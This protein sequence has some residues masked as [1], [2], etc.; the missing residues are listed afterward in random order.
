LLS[1]S[2]GSIASI[3]ITHTIEDVFSFPGELANS[4]LRAAFLL[5]LWTVIARP[6]YNRLIKTDEDT[7]IKSKTLIIIYACSFLLM[8]ISLFA[9]SQAES[10]GYLYMGLADTLYSLTNMTSLV[11]FYFITAAMRFSGKHKTT[12]T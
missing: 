6:F 2:V 11:S 3:L 5:T 12:N 8:S 10:F 4:L 9:A 7:R 1:P